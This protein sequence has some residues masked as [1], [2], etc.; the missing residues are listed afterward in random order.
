MAE[1]KEKQYVSD[2]AQ[3][4]A[5]WNWE[6][7]NE[8]EVNPTQLTLGSHTKV[9]WKCSNG[10]EWQAQI[11]N[12]TNGSG[13]PYCYHA[14]QKNLPSRNGLQKTHEEFLRDLRNRNPNNLTIIGR[15]TTARN[16]IEWE[17]KECK[18]H[19]FSSPKHLY[20]ATG[21][22][23]DCLT[24][25]LAKETIKENKDNF[26]RSLQERDNQPELLEE[27]KGMLKPIKV[28]C[29]ICGY[30]WAATPS[31]LLRYVSACPECARR[32][33]T[34]THANFVRELMRVNPYIKVL[35]E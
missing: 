1:K 5:E 15:Y 29:R 24:A 3:I 17:C 33:R 32:S 20:T 8:I 11:K 10:H 2:N 4:M 28:R 30:I 35:G 27:Y 16:K 13:C 21:L 18:K 12:R 14:R 31:N 19:I 7:N 6:K 9:W 23:S 26:I 22:C 25:I 34:K